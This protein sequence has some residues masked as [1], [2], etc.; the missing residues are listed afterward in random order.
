MCEKRGPVNGSLGFRV[1][2]FLEC[3]ERIRVHAVAEQGAELEADQGLAGALAILDQALGVA[4]NFKPMDQQQK[5]ATLQKTA[6]VGM[7]GKFEQYKSSQIYDGTANS[8][9]WLG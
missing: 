6:P 2:G 4:R 7:A 9:E 1:E 3:V 8:P 5:I